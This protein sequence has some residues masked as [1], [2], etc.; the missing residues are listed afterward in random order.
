M[1]TIQQDILRYKERPLSVYQLIIFLHKEKYHPLRFIVLF[2]ITNYFSNSLGG[3][4]CF[5]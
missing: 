5:L 2:R 4:Y 3:G 1:S